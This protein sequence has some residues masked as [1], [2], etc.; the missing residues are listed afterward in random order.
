MQ[1]NTQQTTLEKFVSDT[2]T[3][4]K[5]NRGQTMTTGAGSDATAGLEQKW[6]ANL[7]ASI[8]NHV[9]PSVAG[10]KPAWRE[11]DGKER[12]RSSARSGSTANAL[13]TAHDF[14]SDVLFA[15]GNVPFRIGLVDDHGQNLPMPAE[16]QAA[17]EEKIEKHLDSR[18]QKCGGV[19]QLLSAADGSAMYGT[20]VMHCYLTADENETSGMRPAFEDVNIWECFWD[21]DNLGELDEG[22]FFNR[23]Q[24]KSRRDVMKWARAINKTALK[25]HG[26]EQI[27]IEALKAS[28]GHGANAAAIGTNGTGDQTGTPE[29][30]DLIYQ[31]KTEVMDEMWIHVPRRAVDDYAQNHVN[32]IKYV[33]P[34]S[35]DVVDAAGNTVATI[36]PPAEG[37]AV[38]GATDTAIPDTNDDTGE[39]VW[40]LT[41]LCNE[42][43]VGMLPEPGKL[44]YKRGEWMRMPGCRDALGIPD[45]NDSNQR[46]LDGLFVAMDNDNKH[47]RT[48]VASKTGTI[49][50]GGRMEDML[51][52]PIAYVE[53]DAGLT[54]AIDGMIKVFNMPTNGEVYMRAIEF[55]NRMSDMDSGVPRIQQGQKSE[56]GNTAF[57]LKQRLDNS[58]RHCGDKIRGLDE[59]IVWIN[60][61]MLK[62]DVELGNIELPSDVE[63]KGGGFRKFSKQLSACSTLMAIMQLA[64]EFPEVKDRMNVAWVL[65][66]YAEAQ[67]QDPEK[68]WISEAEYQNKVQ[69]RG[70]SPEAQQQQQQMQAALEKIQAAT[71]KDNALAQKAIAEA[72]SIG[73][74]VGHADSRLQLDRAKG[75]M[76]IAAKMRGE[77]T[78]A[79]R[80]A[81]TM[82]PSKIVRMRQKVDKAA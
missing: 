75:A 46:V 48:V 2:L 24:R 10:F 72:Q 71:A 38:E 64:K 37:A 1:G 40:I 20:R 41:H 52:K 16:E 7:L 42:K 49:A 31:N 4:A 26:G 22:E 8:P 28:F 57:E 70:Q 56:G 9:M 65:A 3:R 82:E 47:A 66:E 29:S 54:G 23:R 76:D 55:F 13:S 74:G 62:M 35:V 60:S 63:V 18:H 69:Q 73:A 53:V 67:G 5:Q 59:D 43:M 34:D 33:H 15:T 45:R 36:A 6:S 61:W 78:R 50:N 39:Y 14:F 21:M 77:S 58:G 44:P 17:Q 30:T 27:D 19:K 80:R 12:W 81:E 11:S 32:A 25:E 68:Y 79:S 51:A